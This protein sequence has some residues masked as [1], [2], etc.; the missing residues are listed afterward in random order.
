MCLTNCTQLD[1]VF[2]T[3]LL[4]RF[5]LSPTQRHWNGIKYLFRYIRGTTNFGLFYPRGSKQEMIG[6]ADASYL[7]DSH[8]A[9]LCVH[10]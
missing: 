10:M 7:S 8:K 3:N 4:V 2:A 6:Y 1:I 5:S 9:R